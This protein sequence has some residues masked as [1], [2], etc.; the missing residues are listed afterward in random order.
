M[1]TDAAAPTR[2]PIIRPMLLLI[3]PPTVGKLTTAAEVSAQ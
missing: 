1:A 2:L 3:T